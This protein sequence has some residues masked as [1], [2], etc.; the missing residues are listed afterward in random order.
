MELYLDWMEKQEKFA[1]QFYVYSQK[2]KQFETEIK[3]KLG[4]LG[5]AFMPAFS[6]A[7]EL[8]ATADAQHR[9]SLLAVAMLK[10]RFAEGGFPDQLDQLTP[11]YMTN[12]PRDP[13]SWKQLN[14]IKS[15]GHT[16]IYS[17]GEDLKDDEG[18]PW[19][20]KE[21]K[22]DLIFRLGG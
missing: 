4:I 15:D 11:K 12:I 13:F 19:D 5:Y 6:R 10:Y 16:I 1:R 14:M 2:W 8:T 18:K 17:I 20:D 21:R 7:A 9:L 3:K 22:G